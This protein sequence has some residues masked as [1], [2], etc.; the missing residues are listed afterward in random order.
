[1]TA[2][3]SCAKLSIALWM[4]PAASESP[5]RQELIETL[6]VDLAA[7]LVAERILAELA[8]WFAPGF[9]ELA[10]GPLAG[11]VAN[12]PFLVLQLDVVV[13]DLDRRQPSGAVRGQCR[14]DGIL[15][16]HAAPIG[17]VSF[18]VRKPRSAR[19]SRP[20]RR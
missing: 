9:D 19:R 17:D 13:L 5:D 3:S 12:E 15:V 6:L 16:G 1:M 14:L 10:K 20:P 4:M 11:A 7:G 8:K 18:C 2:A